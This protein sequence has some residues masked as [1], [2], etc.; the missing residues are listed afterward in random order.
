MITRLSIFGLG[1]L[2]LPLAALFARSGL[3]TIAIDTDAALVEQLRAGVVPIIEP[4]LEDL[5]AQAASA[6]AYTTDARAAADTDAS[7]ILV[8]TPSQSSHP[9]YSSTY[10]ENACS[11]LCAVLRTRVRWRYHLI[12]ISSTLSPGT[13]STRIVPALEAGL[14]RRAGEDFGI[15]YVPDFGA[16]GEVVSGFQHP[17]FLLIGA[18]AAAVA[19]QASALYR[20]I[21]APQTPICFL[22]TRDAELAK[23]AL[24]VFLCVKIAFGNSLAQLGERLGGADLDAIANTLS[25]DPR[26]GAG[27][28]RGGGPY[29]GSCLPRD[30]DAFIHL[31]RSV[32]L[33]AP[34]AR[35]SAAV[36]AGQYDLIERQ[37][38]LCE[39]RCVAV[40]GLSFKPGTPVTTASPVFEFVRRLLRRS[41]Q[42][43]AFDPM[44]KARE[45]ARAAFGMDISCCNTLAESISRADVILICN[46]DPNFAGL[47]VEVPA[48]RHIV[49]P[50]GCV[51]DPHPGLIQP[52]RVSNRIPCDYPFAQR[53][54]RTQGVP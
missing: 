20:R 38:L 2:G 8:A 42:V 51:R 11:D 40:L 52:G 53:T 47:A 34:L 25:L 27:L 37:V 49:D 15:A 16:L 17:P 5:V 21:I 10:V 30:I 48:D 12:I 39:P 43:V 24:N 33:D 4:E 13:M 29:G 7:I 3:R 50:W 54:L 9:E 1:K 28:L 44:A 18:D 41:I 32:D 19:A 31:A 23:I 46:A 26:I 6:I 22:S 36:N 45:A 14:G 35:A